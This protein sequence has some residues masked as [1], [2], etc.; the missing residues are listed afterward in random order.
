MNLLTTC[1]CCDRAVPFL[2]TQW[3]LG[4]AFAC[5]GCGAKLMIERNYWLGLSAVITFLFARTR[6][7]DPVDQLWLFL[8]LLAMVALAQAQVMKPIV[9]E[10]GR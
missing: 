4:K 8:G 2:K 10:P 5:Q 6:L 3:G 1:P 9:V 7:A